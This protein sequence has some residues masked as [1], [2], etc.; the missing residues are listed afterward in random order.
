[1]VRGLIPPEDIEFKPLLSRKI[2]EETVRKFGYGIA[3]DSRLGPVQVAP[4][5]DAD[6]SLVAQKLRGRDKNFSVRGDISGAL[7]FG[8]HVWPKTGK[9]LVVTEGEI[10]ALTMSQVQGNSWPVVSVPNGAHGARKYVA[11]NRDYFLGFDEVVIMFDMDKAGREAARGVAE[12]LGARARIASLPLKDCNEML[13]AGRTKELLDAMWRAEPYRPE[14]IVDLASL[15]EAV[16]ERPEKGVSWWSEKLTDLTYGIRLGEIY[17]FGAGTGVGKTDFFTQQI[18][19]LATQGHACGVFS[20]E[21][22]PVETAKRIAGKVAGKPFHIP[23]AGWT[24]ED[25]EEAWNKLMKSG[26]VFLYDSFGANKWETIRDK[27]EYLVHAHGVR[28]I[29]LDHLTALAA[30][31]DDE[32]VAL[33]RTMAEIGSL[34]KRLN[35]AMFLVSH[36]ATPES[37]SHEEGARV[38]IR[39]FKGSRAIGFWC[40]YMFG[41]ERN[42][43]SD[44]EEERTTTYFRVLK[45]RYTGRATGVV[46]A[47]GYDRETG[48]LYEKQPELYEAFKEEETFSEEGCAPSDF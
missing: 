20:L 26:K 48:L 44:D 40:H 33:E 38:T 4:Y 25:L 37:G 36:L 1:M 28:Y 11:E 24:D 9:K 35:I 6:G 22:H 2:T 42:Q 16:K 39:Q 12:V 3:R 30:A 17:A 10:D 31:E 5:Y 32:R 15:K 45:D 21:Q 47:L 23:D 8:A 27:I 46:Y 43:Q 41:L 7:P 18:A 14:G 13:Q 34:V 19:H 29:F